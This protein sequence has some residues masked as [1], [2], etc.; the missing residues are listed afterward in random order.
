[1][2]RVEERRVEKGEERRRAAALQTQGQS[3]L[4]ILFLYR[5]SSGGSGE[6]FK[7]APLGNPFWWKKMLALFWARKCSCSI[8]RGGKQYE[9]NLFSW[10]S[11]NPVRLSF[12]N[13]EKSRASSRS[14][15]FLN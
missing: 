10:H 5:L 3:R 9:A 6:N 12:L 8:F 14:E 11:Q 1:M 2:R 15:V 7:V 4:L 13:P